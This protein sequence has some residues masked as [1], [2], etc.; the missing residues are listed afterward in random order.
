[1]HYSGQ[2]LSL[3]LGTP[4]KLTIGN[5]IHQRALIEG[6]WRMQSNLENDFEKI[7]Q[8]GHWSDWVR[9]VQGGWS[10]ESLFFA[11]V[12]FQNATVATAKDKLISLDAQIWREWTEIWKCFLK[13]ERTAFVFLFCFVLIGQCCSLI[14]C[15]HWRTL[16]RWFTKNSILQ[17]KT[18]LNSHRKST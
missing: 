6:V 11:F 8:T 3:L 17:S 7:R 13:G 15:R 12:F 1:M 4:P 9:L 2:S 16:L 14:K 5:T 10:Y 18:K